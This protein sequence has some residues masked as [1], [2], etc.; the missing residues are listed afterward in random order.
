[1]YFLYAV[2]VLVL[3]VS[4]YYIFQNDLQDKEQFHQQNIC[5]VTSPIKASDLEVYVINM[6]KN[7]DRLDNFIDQYINSD[8]R[9][10]QFNRMRA[11]DG[12]QVKIEDYVSERALREITDAEK[13]GYRTKHYQLS[14]GAVGCYL[15]HHGVYKKVVAQEKPYAMIF[16][17]DVDIDQNI[18]AK[19][20]KALEAVPS[21]WDMVLLGCFC[22]KCVRNPVYSDV[23]RFFLLHGYVINKECAVKLDKY[24]AGRKIEQQVDWE[25][26]NMITNE[27]LKVYCL[28]SPIAKQKGFKTNIQT[29][30]KIIPGINP[31]ATI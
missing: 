24:L 25:L 18:F 27:N 20:N 26:S 14:R 16:E 11:I 22:I 5:P 9:H 2:T 30:L 23:E 8:L 28:R 1:M 15:S 13:S 3:A 4:L 10:I 31:Y 17:D 21:D 29:P 12:K 7:K 19:T 6:D